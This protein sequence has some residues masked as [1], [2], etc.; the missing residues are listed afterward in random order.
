MAR[1]NQF[2]ES[3]INFVELMPQFQ[4][5]CDIGSGNGLVAQEWRHLQNIPRKVAFD[6]GTYAEELNG[7]K[8]FDFLDPQWEKRE[9]KFDFPNELFSLV[10]VMDMIQYLYKPDGEKL[11]DWLDEHATKMIVIW[12]PDGF[13]PCAAHVSCWHEEEFKKRG[14]TTAIAEKFHTG[15]PIVGNGLLA[16]KMK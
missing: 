6:P 1:V 5:W 4:S 14:Y 3:K 2:A 13:Y 10:T 11:L 8:V 12:T 16:W 9:Q 15:P 7:R